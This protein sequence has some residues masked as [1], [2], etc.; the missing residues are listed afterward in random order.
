MGAGRRT[1]WRGAAKMLRSAR[2]MRLR[3]LLVRRSRSLG[4]TEVHPGSD[5]TGGRANLCPHFV[6]RHR[7]Q[8]R[9]SEG[10]D[11]AQRLNGTPEHPSG[12]AAQRG[13]TRPATPAPQWRR[14]R[15]QAAPVVRI[16]R[17]PCAEKRPNTLRGAPALPRKV[18][19][20]KSTIR[21]TVAFNRDPSGKPCPGRAQSHSCALVQPSRVIQNGSECGMTPASALGDR[22]SSSLARPT[23]VL[24]K[25]RGPLHTDALHW[26]RRTQP[27]PLKL[28][29]RGAGARLGKN[30]QGHLT[31]GSASCQ[32]IDPLLALRRGR[33]VHPSLLIVSS[34]T[35]CRRLDSSMPAARCCVSR[36]AA[37]TPR[38]TARPP[39]ADPCCPGQ[40]LWRKHA[41]FM[42]EINKA[43][44]KESVWNQRHGWS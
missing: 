31:A 11:P 26:H 23:P 2:R 1:P 34:T 16:A 21:T 39:G 18:G 3:R 36:Y 37:I 19:H 40:R 30:T 15:G 35:S 17:N 29:D 4:W 32:I 13:E 5:G 43:R 27:W 38:R 10:P 6:A 41:G 28:L 20:K 14:G 7:C 25:L 42:S 9:L 24:D 12:D 8:P 22:R 44:R 33:R